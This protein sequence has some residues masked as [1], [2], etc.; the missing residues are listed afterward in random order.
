MGQLAI[1]DLI[2]HNSYIEFITEIVSVFFYLNIYFKTCILV[3]YMF[4]LVP[5]VCEIYRVAQK[6]VYSLYSSI[7]L[8]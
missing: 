6:N 1:R 2:L 3:S 8:E 7:S 5:K 4:S